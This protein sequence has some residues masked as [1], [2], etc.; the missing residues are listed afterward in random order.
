MDS[1]F[2]QHEFMVCLF[3]VAG[4][5]KFVFD[6]IALDLTGQF[7]KDMLAKLDRA[8]RDRDALLA[9]AKAALPFCEQHE[10]EGPAGEGWRSGELEDVIDA[11]HKAIA[12]SEIDTFKWWAKEANHES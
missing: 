4:S 2:A 8:Q 11:L 9:A 3:L 6:I 12:E 1:F 7:I 10:D 5:G